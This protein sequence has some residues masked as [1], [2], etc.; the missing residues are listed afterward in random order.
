MHIKLLSLKGPIRAILCLVLIRGKEVSRMVK[1]KRVLFGGL[2]ALL[3]L[4]LVACGS[5][6]T[7]D[8][9]AI[10][11]VLTDSE[12]AWDKIEE[13]SV[14]KV[15][16]SGTLYPNLSRQGNRRTDRLRGGNYP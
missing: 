5:G 9:S 15:A 14:L 12:T 6:E 4:T 11:T 2:T 1:K 7:V 10:D 13:A 16:T 3:G 8:S